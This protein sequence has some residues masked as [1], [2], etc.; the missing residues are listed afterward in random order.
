MCSELCLRASMGC[1]IENEKGWRDVVVD[2]AT[3]TGAAW[4]STH[5]IAIVYIDLITLTL[6]WSGLT[7]RRAPMLM[8]VNRRDS[9][10]LIN[11]GA[12]LPAD[13]LRIGMRGN[14]E[15]GKVDL[16]RRVGNKELKGAPTE[17]THQG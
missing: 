9:A 3:G 11:I 4:M 5:V 12:L 13:P 1:E 15:G 6:M 16:K 7:R 17:T 10:T 8:S 14:G 2:V